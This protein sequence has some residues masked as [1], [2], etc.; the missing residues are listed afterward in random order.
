MTRLCEH[1]YNED[2]RGD[3]HLG[4]HF[5]DVECMPF[6]K[7]AVGKTREEISV[8]EM[9]AELRPDSTCVIAAGHFKNYNF[10][11][12]LRTVTCVFVQHCGGRDVYIS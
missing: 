12:R 9:L 2:E 5:R 10:R 3:G 1:W 6:G 4:I 7:C 11:T 8:W